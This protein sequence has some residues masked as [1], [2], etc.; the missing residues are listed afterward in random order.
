MKPLIIS[1]ILFF[2]LAPTLF[3]CPEGSEPRIRGQRVGSGTEP[4]FFKVGEALSTLEYADNYNPKLDIECKTSS[5]KGTGMNKYAKAIV[6]TCHDREGGSISIPVV[7]TSTIGDQ[8]LPVFIKSK[9]GVNFQL[10]AG[11]F[12]VQR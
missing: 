11:C 7:Y 2:S 1:I 5:F 10:T 12:P 9:D 4:R 6:V 3:A 8:S